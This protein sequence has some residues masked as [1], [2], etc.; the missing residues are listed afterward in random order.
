M[1]NKVL[2]FHISLLTLEIFYVGIG[3]IKR[4]YIKRK[5]NQLWLNIVN[6]YGYYV[7][8]IETNLSLEEVYLLER[9]YIKEYGR[10]DLGTG[11]LAN[12]TDGGDGSIKCVRTQ[13]QRN[14][15]SKSLIGNKNS[16]GRKV[17]YTKERNNKIANSMLDKNGK[18]INQFS[19][20]GIFIKSFPSLHSAARYINSPYS[21]SNIHK[22]L[23][24]KLKTC[25]GFIWRYE[26][27]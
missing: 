23:N 20:D 24:G 14:K 15:I 11:T 17:Q 13:D 5:R 26:N 18:S 2:Y 3:D 19:T 27:N 8:I 12:M 22:A 16:V 1:N 21:A 7:S 9:K 6:K 10:R 4:P 25:K